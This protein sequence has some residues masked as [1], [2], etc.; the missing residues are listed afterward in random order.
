MENSRRLAKTWQYPRHREHERY[1]RTVAAQ[2]FQQNGFATH[3]RKPFVLANYTDWANNI[4]LPEVAELIR[5][6]R[7]GFPLHNHISLI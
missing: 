1:L 6:R 3:P 2:W 4:I 7:Q 5:N